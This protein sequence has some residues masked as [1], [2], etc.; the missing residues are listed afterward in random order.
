M[1]RCVGPLPR[2]DSGPT[3][4]HDPPG[5]RGGVPPQTGP[6][7]DTDVVASACSLTNFTPGGSPHRGRYRNGPGPALAAGLKGRR[8][9]LTDAHPATT[10]GSRRWSGTP[11]SRS[12]A[13]PA[14]FHLGRGRTRRSPLR[15]HLSGPS[16]PPLAAESEALAGTQRP[17]D[18]RHDDSST[19]EGP[20]VD[21]CVLCESRDTVLGRVCD[22]CSQGLLS[23]LSDVERDTRDLVG[24]GDLLGAVK[25]TGDPYSYRGSRGLGSS[26]P[27][28]LRVIAARDP[29]TRPG[30]EPGERLYAPAEVLADWADALRDDLALAQGDRTLEASVHLLRAGHAHVCAA[31]WLPDYADELR[32]L[33]GFLGSLST[34]TRTLPRRPLGACVRDDCDGRVWRTGGDPVCDFCGCIYD[35]N[36]VRGLADA[37]QRAIV[38][39]ADSSSIPDAADRFGVRTSAI[40]GWVTRG[41][42]RVIRRVDGRPWVSVEDVAA[43][44][45]RLHA[46]G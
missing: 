23:V 21:V 42:V 13:E 24:V 40:R 3:G 46:A 32:D 45:E 6:D 26:T 7:A 37:A 20:P 17:P 18:G 12:P 27:A 31:G 15:G 33:R 43:R 25:A 19:T 44:A 36:R 30:G 10:R 35:P 11:G 2:A 5:R 28:D 34:T 8:T 14:P 1:S 41:H 16:R 39:A 38:E 29:R 4:G 9:P 22:P